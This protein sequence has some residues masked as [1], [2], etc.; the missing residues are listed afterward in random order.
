MGGTDRN[1]LTEDSRCAK[2]QSGSCVR[3]GE[4][5]GHNGEL[6]ARGVQVWD[7]PSLVMEDTT[8]A[9]SGRKNIHETLDMLSL[10]YL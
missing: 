2:D 3:N 9:K 7:S 1:C 10:R 8:E 6:D 4:G 5:E